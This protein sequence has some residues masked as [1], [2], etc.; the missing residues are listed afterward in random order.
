MDKIHLYIE[1]TRDLLSF[2]EFAILECTE[3]F[4]RGIISLLEM[5]YTVCPHIAPICRLFVISSM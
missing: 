3:E 1:W 5:A 2:L 4:G